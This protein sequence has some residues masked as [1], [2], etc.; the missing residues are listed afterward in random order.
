MAE[1]IYYKIPI[2]E[3]VY[4]RDSFVLARKIID[5]GYRPDFVIPIWRGGTPPMTYVTGALKRKKIIH[6]HAP[7]QGYSYTDI[8]RQKEVGIRLIDETIDII[9]GDSE[10][11][12][13]NKKI[14]KN[15]LLGD[16][17]FDTGRTIK[18]FIEKINATVKHQFNLKI[19]T[20]YWKPEA[21]LTE[22]MPDYYVRTYY[23]ISAGNEKQYP[24]IVFPHEVDDLTDDELKIYYPDIA[25]VIL[26]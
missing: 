8:G 6:E 2:N 11:I 24:W 15:L 16:D 21:N 1:K 26:G 3:S 14:Y 12:N 7:T 20:V 4:K 19:A 13:G 18:K 23:P 9:N 22:I 5:S 25:E 10:D 17:V